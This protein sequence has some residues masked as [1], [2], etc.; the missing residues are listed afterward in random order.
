MGSSQARNRT[1]V[2]CIG[3][4]ILYHWATRK[5]SVLLFS[6]FLFHCTEIS[7]KQTNLHFNQRA[8]HFKELATQIHLP[9]DWELGGSSHGV[10]KLLSQSRQE[11][12]L[13]LALQPVLLSYYICLHGLFL[14]PLV[15]A[16]S[17]IVYVRIL[18]DFLYYTLISKLFKVNGFSDDKRNIFSFSNENHKAHSSITLWRAMCSSYNPSTIVRTVTKTLSYDVGASAS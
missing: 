7:G 1:L 4:R 9:G 16:L 14:P 13:G 10:T 18:N 6:A 12:V 8:V 11:T 17:S 5:P 3:R 15:P 2:S